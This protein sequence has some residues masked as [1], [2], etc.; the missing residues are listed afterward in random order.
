MAILFLGE[1][2]S[3]LIVLGTATVVLSV[4]LIA[5]ARSSNEEPTGNP[6]RGILFALGTSVCWA[7]A[8]VF[9][10]LVLANHDPL[11]MNLVRMLIIL[12]VVSAFWRLPIE[13][14]PEPHPSRRRLLMM[15][16][17]GLIGIGVGDTLLFIGL[18]TAQAQ[19]VVPLAATSPLF[20][21]LFSVILLRERMN[22]RVAAGI[23]TAVAG[24]M[25]LTFP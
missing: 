7:C 10:K 2:F 20:A 25:L 14:L 4:W 5:G 15:S 8:M 17:G 23:L 19:V 12:P 1:D 13:R 24:V 3:E 16:L 21:G 9:M 6:R 18:H 22:K 11:V